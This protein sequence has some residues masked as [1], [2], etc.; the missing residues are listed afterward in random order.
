LLLVLGLLIA[1]RQTR[2]RPPPAV[3]APDARLKALLERHPPC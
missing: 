3:V 1:W 2:R